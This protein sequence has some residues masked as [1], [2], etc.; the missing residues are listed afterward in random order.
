M[1]AKRV[2]GEVRSTPLPSRW[3]LGGAMELA[4][5]ALPPVAPGIRAFAAVTSNALWNSEVRFSLGAASSVVSL[6]PSDRTRL[7]GVN[8][9]ATL[10]TVRA[11]LCPKLWA[12]QHEGQSIELRGCALV[13]G[14]AW[15][16]RTS[17]AVV[18]GGSF[19]HE[20]GGAGGTLRAR[21]GLG[22]AF[23]EAESTIRAPWSR[24]EF[25]KTNPA[26]TFF[27]VSPITTTA[28][29]GAGVVFD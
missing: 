5:G 28:S 16:G 9:D 8:L 2:E 10:A 19:S 29:I 24:P 23:F 18:G 15:F 26:R 27:T 20:W 21:Y 6:G 22:Q 17:G 14:G 4:F 3:F 1:V 13:E 25:L 7:D 11:E 12:A